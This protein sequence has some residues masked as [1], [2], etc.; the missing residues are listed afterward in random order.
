MKINFTTASEEMVI[1]Y[2]SMFLL[3]VFMD[4]PF[5]P[6]NV[7]GRGVKWIFQLSVGQNSITLGLS[8]SQRRIRPILCS[9]EIVMKITEK[10]LLQPVGPSLV[11]DC[12][13]SNNFPQT[14]T[15]ET[16]S[17]N[18]LLYSLGWHGMLVSVADAPSHK[19]YSAIFHSTLSLPYMETVYC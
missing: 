14:D 3:V 10:Y 16:I 5:F 6:K 12:N 2:L 9:S 11:E 8:P 19:T 17:D 7:I 18:R 13:K 4:S 15:T 1:F